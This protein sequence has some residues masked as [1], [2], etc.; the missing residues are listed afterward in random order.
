MQ[1]TT[2]RLLLRTVK[3][4]DR[5]DLHNLLSDKSVMQYV[6]SGH[7]LTENEIIKLITDQFASSPTH[8]Y[9]LG[10]LT[11]RLNSTF[12]GVAGLLPVD[13]L[14]R[15]DYELGFIIKPSHHRKGIATEIALAQAEY[16][17]NQ[18][19]GIRVLATVHPENSPSINLLE[20]IGFV[21]Q[22][23]EQ[24]PHRGIRI[25]YTKELT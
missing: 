22:Q 2:Q 8:Q 3:E 13:F 18:L 17:A 7:P 12:Y 11:D 20:K 1:I 25:I 14:N 19:N 6:F 16:V 5:K 15:Q 24:L 4:S 23:K 9:G 10:V 21:H